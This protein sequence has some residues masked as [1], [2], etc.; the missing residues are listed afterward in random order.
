MN[1]PMK[2]LRG[3]K[4]LLVDAVDHGAG[5]IEKVHLGTAKRTF[6]V[7]EAIPGLDEPS[8]LVHV[9]HDASVH[10]VYTTVRLV[11]RGVGAALGLVLD[12][13]NAIVERTAEDVSSGAPTPADPPHADGPDERNRS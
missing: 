11:T 10:G 1:K 12:G 3:L 8:K 9:V 7:L 6:D 2:R 13:A 4:D 5:A